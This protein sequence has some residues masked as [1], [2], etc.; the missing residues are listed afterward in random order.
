MNQVIIGQIDRIL[1]QNESQFFVA[2]LDSGQ[3]ISGVYLDGDVDAIKGLAVTIEGEWE[4][5]KKYGKTFKFTSIKV[6]QNELFFFLTKIIKGFSKKLAHQLIEHFGE[7]RLVE[8]L[9]NDIDQLKEFKGIKEKRA[10][11]IQT[12]WKKFRSMRKLGEFLTPYDVSAT[13]LTTIASAMRDVDEAC[14]K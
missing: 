8:I 7:E 10:P 1:Y 13:L 11:K 2:I 14:T 6:N 12:S 5:H 9:D 4:D 3:K